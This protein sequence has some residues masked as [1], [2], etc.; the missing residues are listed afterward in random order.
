MESLSLE[1]ENIIRDTR[2]L[3]RLKKNKITTTKIKINKNTKNKIHK[4]NKL[5]KLKIEY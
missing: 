2:N 5:K 3:L 4:K 1:E